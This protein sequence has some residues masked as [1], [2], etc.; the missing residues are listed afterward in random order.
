MSTGKWTAVHAVNRTSVCIVY[1]YVYV[2]L[3]AKNIAMSRRQN[4][5][6]RDMYMYI[7]LNQDLKTD[8]NPPFVA[9][10]Y[11]F[12]VNTEKRHLSFIAANPSH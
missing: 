10:K 5:G 3:A 12:N 7:R 11:D 4:R 6:M 1:V 9:S 8:L 2:H